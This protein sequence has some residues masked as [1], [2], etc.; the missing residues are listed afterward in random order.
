MSH[1]QEIG[2]AGEVQGDAKQSINRRLH[3]RC[4][5]VSIYARISSLIVADEI[6]LE[7]PR[8]LEM[9]RTS[10]GDANSGD[11]ASSYTYLA[12]LIS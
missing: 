6:C 7:M 2:D 8:L 11:A 3:Y 1:I 9:C 4:G 5:C 12:S 10:Y